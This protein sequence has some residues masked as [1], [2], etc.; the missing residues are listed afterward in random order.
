VLSAREVSEKELAI[1]GETCRMPPY[2]ADRG[3][4]AKY[5]RLVKS[6]SLGFVTDE[7]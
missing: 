3:T 1:R 2:K 4:L 7:G 5:V 6:A